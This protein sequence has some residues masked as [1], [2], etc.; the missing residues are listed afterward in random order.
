[1]LTYTS[2]GAWRGAA[3][4][5]PPGVI[6]F[7]EIE[8]ARLNQRAF[9]IDLRVL[10]R[11]PPTLA[12]FPDWDQP[13]HGVIAIADKTVQNRI[14]REAERLVRSSPEIIEVRGVGSRL[15]PG[16]RTSLT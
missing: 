2:S 3:P 12:W 14:L 4:R 9:H 1:M 6:E 11:V 7:N 8:A 13:G 16:A 15:A 5:V 10:A